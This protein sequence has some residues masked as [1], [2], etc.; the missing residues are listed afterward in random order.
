MF[1][2]TPNPP[3]T[4]GCTETDPVSPSRKPAMAGR[5]PN[6]IFTIVPTV[7]SETLL[8]HACETLAS[9]SVMASELAFILE[10]P[11]CNLALAIQQM[12]SLAEL[13]VNRVLDQVD[14]QE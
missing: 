2:V 6:P 3:D 4:D 5:R 8:V 9:A 12:I 14:P 1:K 13:S 11:K 10:G 7:N